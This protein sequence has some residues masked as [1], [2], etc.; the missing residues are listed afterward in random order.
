MR[1]KHASQLRVKSRKNS[2]L[3][4]LLQQFEAALL[5]SADVSPTAPSPKARLRHNDSRTPHQP[6]TPF[7]D[8]K[9]S[10]ML[11]SSSAHAQLIG[12]AKS[13]TILLKVVYRLAQFCS[14]GD[15]SSWARLNMGSKRPQC[16][17]DSKR[18]FVCHQLFPRPPQQKPRQAA[19]MGINA[20][21]ICKMP[22]PRKQS[23]K[24]LPAYVC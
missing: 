22:W 8:W 20:S 15:D 14:G 19:K 17:T 13:L 1:I 3:A 4:L 12:L 18:V 24:R 7:R 10:P 2:S 21:G 6:R 5:P 16:G 11:L 23:V 9:G